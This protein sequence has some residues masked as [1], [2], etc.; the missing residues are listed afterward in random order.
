MN[1]NAFDTDLNEYDQQFADTPA[2]ETEDVPD[3]KYRVIVE[4]VEITRA[5][6]SGNPMLKWTLKIADQA[7]TNRFLWNHHV[8][9]NSTGLS[10]L[11]KDLKLCGV[12]LAKLSDLPENLEK[13]LDIPLEVLVITRGDHQNV[14]FKR[15]MSDSEVP[16]VRNADL[17][18]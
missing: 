16:E 11:K 1:H 15:R 4:K 7:H 14:Y 3:G 5:R 18:F 6:T 12:I 8:L 17:P 9:N 13:L 10:W 2:F